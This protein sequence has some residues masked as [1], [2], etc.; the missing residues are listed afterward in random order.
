MDYNQND[1]VVGLSL[2]ALVPSGPNRTM[3]N[4]RVEAKNDDASGIAWSP[5]LVTD[6]ALHGCTAEE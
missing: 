5:P 2:V 1:R 4:P 3:H 6:V